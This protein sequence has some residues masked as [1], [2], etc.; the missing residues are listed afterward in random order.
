M[1]FGICIPIHGD[2]GTENRFDILK[3]VVQ[4]ADNSEVDS[5]W[6]EDHF[7]IPENET[8]AS[9]GLPGV[10]EPLEA[11]TTL[12]AFASWTKKVKIGTEVTPMTLRHPVMLAKM[13]A[14]VDIISKGRAILGA[15]AGWNRT[16]F[17][18]FALPFET[19]SQRFEKMRESVEI[20]L[21]LWTERQVHYRGK[22]Y[23][24]EGGTVAPKPVSNPHPPIWFGGFSE[25]IL[26]FVAKYGNGWINATNPSAE[27]F[28]KQLSRLRGLVRD[29]LNPQDEI[30]IALPYMT[31]VSRDRKEAEDE[32]EGYIKRGNFKGMLRFFADATRKYGI[33]GNIEDCV[34]K[35]KEKAALCAN[36]IIFDV[37]PPKNALRS[38][39]IICREII[40]AINRK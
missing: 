27:D 7:L 19:R 12:A 38:V 5:I 28:N 3:D 35:V 25:K 33:W 8:L 30:D 39:P 29:Y 1:K 14:T 34:S 10:D 32:M 6:V 18:R 13:V 17:E 2:F 40:P 11:W 4:M 31:F 36:N 15:G 16:E 9:Q 24:I 37:R 20:V 22:F 23:N 21:R 26:E